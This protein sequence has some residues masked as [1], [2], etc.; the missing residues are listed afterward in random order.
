[1]C[2][3][4]VSQAQRLQRMAEFLGKPA[5]LLAVWRVGPVI[6]AAVHALQGRRV[7]S[8]WVPELQF[9][10]PPAPP[11]KNAGQRCRL[12]GGGCLGDT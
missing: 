11:C 6:V 5:A 8:P 1:M 10:L 7:R 4:R 12:E 3:T 2:P 9:Q